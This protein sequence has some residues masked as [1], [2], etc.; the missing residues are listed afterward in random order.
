MR[1]SISSLLGLSLLATTGLANP[2]SRSSDDTAA[3]VEIHQLLNHYSQILDDKTYSDLSSVLI[4]DAVF[5]LPT[6]NYTGRATA[7]TRYASEFEGKITLHTV[8]NVYVSNI[9]TTTAT[10]VGSGVTIYFGQGNLTGQAVTD[11]AKVT[12][13]VTKESGSWLIAETTIGTG[14]SSYSLERGGTAE[15]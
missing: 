2:V 15:C 6:L 3:I 14:V 10:V 5:H 7:E 11:Y 9:T 8:E 12:Y 4:E 1:F 13:S